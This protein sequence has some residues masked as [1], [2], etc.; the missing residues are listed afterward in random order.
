MSNL[1]THIRL[2]TRPGRDPGSLSN[3][4]RDRAVPGRA[5]HLRRD[6][7]TSSPTTGCCSRRWRARASTPSR[8][9]GTT[10]RSTGPATT[11]S[12]SARPGTTRPAATSSSPGRPPVP[13]LANPADVVAWNTDK[14]YLA[15]AGRRRRAGRPDRPGSSPGDAWTPPPTPAS[16]SSSRRSAPAAG[17][18]PLRP[19]RPGHRDL[20]AAHVARLQAA[21]RLVMVQPYLP[22]VD[23]V[24]RDRA[25]VLRRSGGAGFSHAIRKGPMLD[26]PGPGA[27]GPLQGRGDHR[28][29]CPTAGRAGGR[30]SGSLARRCPAGRAAA[31]RPGRPD[32]RPGRR[33]G[34]G[35]AGAHRAVAVPGHA[36]GAADR[37]ADAIGPALGTVRRPHPPRSRRGPVV[38]RPGTV[39]RRRRRARRGGR[40]P[41][42][43]FAASTRRTDRVG[44]PDQAR[45]RPCAAPT[46][47]TGRCGEVLHEADQ[48]PAP[49]R[50]RPGRA[51][52]GGR[53]GAPTARNANH[54]ADRQP[55]QQEDQVGVHLGDRLRVE[56]VAGGVRVAG[57]RAAAGDHRCRRRAPRR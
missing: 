19:G 21:G 9:S 57:V 8:P 5:G 34:A 42:A 20:A 14:R 4:R 26:R 52:P 32:P 39:P 43:P 12:C 33:A 10:R 46:S 53:R 55:E 49:A 51:A 3:R 36:A 6:P 41:P 25:A 1:V 48:R 11:W 23:T 38:S 15:R 16:A 30:P 35:R 31:L 44:Q 56:P 7:P 24:R 37:L 45:P 27:G 50:R 22:A 17:H 29:G 47:S 28:R 18:R 54:S 40:S 2:T 13:R